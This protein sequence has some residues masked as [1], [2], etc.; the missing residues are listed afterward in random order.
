LQDLVDLD[1]KI[2]L[3]DLPENEQPLV[4]QILTAPT[5]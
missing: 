5:P 1:A 2:R 3:K 4:E